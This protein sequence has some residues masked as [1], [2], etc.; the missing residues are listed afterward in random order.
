MSKQVILYGPNTKS[1]HS[2]NESAKRLGT[3]LQEKNY[4]CIHGGGEGVMSS[5]TETMK[6]ENIQLVIPKHMETRLLVYNKVPE[7]NKIIVNSIHERIGFYL[8]IS[9]NVKYI[10]VYAG[11]IGTIHEVFSIMVHWYMDTK[12]MPEFLLCTVNGEAWIEQL[13]SLLRP[14]KISTRPYM[15]DILSKIK[16]VSEEELI[17]LL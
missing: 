4:T 14:L 6:G 3:K 1:T 12:N 17:A 11:G 7:K 9:R 8:P 10:I 5:I 15:T 2:Q 16:T 13:M